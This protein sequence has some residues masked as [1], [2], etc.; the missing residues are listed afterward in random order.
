[1]LASARRP[2]A[3]LV[4]ALAALVVGAL[5]TDRAAGRA[6]QTPC[7]AAVPYPGDTAPRAQLAR[8]MGSA[9][10]AAGLPPELPVMA[11]LVDSGLRNRPARG[12]ADSV[13]FF[14]MRA[15]I[16]DTGEYKGFSSRP[17]LQLKWFLDSAIAAKMQ[18]YARGANPTDPSS[19]GT[20]IADVER[21]AEAFRGRYQLKLE[22]AR[23][24]LGTTVP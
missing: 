21:P 9:A 22:E 19:W 4:A 17:Q 18:R 20:W 11:A 1:M 24:L 15:S 2:R 6:S 3:A 8:W 12:G 7:Y 14:Q 13:G 5:A 16:W 10:R 23:R